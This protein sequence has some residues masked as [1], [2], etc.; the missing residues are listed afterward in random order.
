MSSTHGRSKPPPQDHRQRQATAFLTYNPD[1]FSASQEAYKL[2]NFRKNSVV[3][4][5]KATGKKA[6]SSGAQMGFI[7]KAESSA[8]KDARRDDKSQNPP[9][10]D[11][12]VAGKNIVTSPSRGRP[13]KRVEASASDSENNEE[14][15]DLPKRKSPARARKQGT[16]P[17]HYKKVSRSIPQSAPA[18]EDEFLLVEPLKSDIPG[19]ELMFSSQESVPRYVCTDR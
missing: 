17:K 5:E 16:T 14:L 12:K 11:A 7:P 6:G 1:E 3:N 9:R 10:K 15:P 2:P 19:M 13:S 18:S 8:P 4:A